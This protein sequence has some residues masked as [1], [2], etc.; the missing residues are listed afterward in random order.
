MVISDL[1]NILVSVVAPC[2]LDLPRQRHPLSMIGIAGVVCAKG[3]APANAIRLIVVIVR[4][5]V[6]P[7]CATPASGRLG[8][9]IVEGTIYSRC[10]EHDGGHQCERNGEV[11]GKGGR[12]K[13]L[14]R[15]RGKHELRRV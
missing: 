6:L 15:A 11:G 8:D 1:L 4:H 10:I 12:P 2:A 14:S 7:P 9:T 3:G 5:D 13:C